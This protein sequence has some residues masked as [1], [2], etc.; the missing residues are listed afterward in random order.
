MAALI[1]VIVG[2]LVTAGA[3]YGLEKLTT[4]KP[5]DLTASMQQ[6]ADADAKKQ[7]QQE[8]LTKAQ[9]LRRSAPDAQAQTGGSLTD[10]PFAALTSDIAGI[11]GDIQQAFKLLGGKDD[12]TQ[13]L[14]FSGGF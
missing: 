9:L 6:Q 4:P 3:S 11:P 5:P 13:G 2:S 1:P 10:M 8:Q 12:S 7:Q 14:S